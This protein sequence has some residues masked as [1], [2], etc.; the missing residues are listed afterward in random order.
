[1]IFEFTP[2]DGSRQTVRFDL[3]GLVEHVPKVGEACGWKTI[4][5]EA[6]MRLN[7]SVVTA[8]PHGWDDGTLVS[9]GQKSSEC[10]SP[11]VMPKALAS[12]EK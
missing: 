11:I 8:K 10:I 3:Q 9:L 12:P 7:V 5:P 6:A 1:L 4:Y 2:F